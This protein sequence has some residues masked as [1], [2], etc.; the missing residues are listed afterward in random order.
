MPDR[1][2]RLL[3]RAALGIAFVA[4]VAI[5][6]IALFVR[7]AD[8]PE[9]WT[10]TAAALAVITS[11]IS[12]WSSRRVLEIQEDA[13][14]PSPTPA[15]DFKSRYGLA[16]LR[17]TNSGAA[18]AYDIHLE[19]DVDLTD[20][21]NKKIGFFKTENQDS[22]AIL[23]P[24]ESVSQVIDAPHNFLSRLPPTDFTGHIVFHDATEREYRRPFRLSARQYEGTPSNDEEWPKTQHELQKIPEELQ[25]IR[26]LLEK[27]SP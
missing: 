26:R 22:I 11:V 5:P 17:I 4:A 27:I 8:K 13:Q 12:T 23:L 6:L 24:K 21:H 14:R 15:F 18:T 2:N 10:V 19:W 16:L 1:I 3:T 25:K 20:H 7:G 9:T